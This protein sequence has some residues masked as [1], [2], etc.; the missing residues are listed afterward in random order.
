MTQRRKYAQRNLGVIEYDILLQLSVG[1]M[2][3]GM[4]LSG[5]SSK[6]MFAAARV[7]A[8]RRQST[9]RAL[10]RMSKAGFI[11]VS[12]K[13][14]LHLTREGKLLLERSIAEMRAKTR[15]GKEKWDGQWRLITFDIPERV[16]GA[17]DA[18]RLVLKRAGFVQLQQSVWIHPFECGELQLLLQAEPRLG[19]RVV[20]ARVTEMSGEEK[21]LDYFKL[22]KAAKRI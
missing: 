18:L 14:T 2:L 1:D 12:S 13:D 19:Q 6:R 5:R 3:A 15:E 10:D 11:E 8:A 7:R 21:L 20:Y 16:R 9:Q 17:R 4:L 22:S